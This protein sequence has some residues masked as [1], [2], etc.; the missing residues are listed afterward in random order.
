MKWRS[1]WPSR[2]TGG[3]TE[4]LLGSRVK[5]RDFALLR[6]DDN[7]VLGG[8]DDARQPCLRFGQLMLRPHLLQDTIDSFRQI[9]EI[10]ERFSDK[11]AYP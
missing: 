5:E 2:L 3:T 9:I 11:I 6:H 8:P 7:G 1:G 10:F 4:H